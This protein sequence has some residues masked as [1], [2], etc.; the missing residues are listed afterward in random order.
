MWKI[1]D[2]EIDRC[3][4]VIAGMNTSDEQAVERFM[5]RI[6]PT[7]NRLHQ[8]A[9]LTDQIT[10]LLLAGNPE[11][12]AKQ[13]RSRGYNC[14]AKVVC[15]STVLYVWDGSGMT[16]CREDNGRIALVLDEIR[17]GGK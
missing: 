12:A 8:N 7:I 13:F 16:R 3:A 4:S 6:R 14:S 1:P 9:Q 15:G 2:Q 11:R 10:S 5:D 17:I